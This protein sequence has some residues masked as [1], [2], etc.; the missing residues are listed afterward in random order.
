MKSKGNRETYNMR[1]SKQILILAALLFSFLCFPV[2]QVFA[3]QN[4]AEVSLKVKQKFIV[5]NPVKEMEFTGNYEFCA[6]DQEAPIPENAKDGIY[7]FSLNGEQA[8]T[9]LSLK[10]AR[11]GVYRY[12][13]KQT[14]EDKDKYQYDKSCYE[15]T[16]YVKNGE[17]GEFITQ[18]IAE[19]GDGKKSGEL[20]F[21]NSYQGNPS[22][23]SKPSDLS[24]PGTPGKPVKTGDTTPIM[25]YVFIAAG[26]LLLIGAL[27]WFRK[28]NQK[29][30]R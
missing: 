24:K 29:K 8:E 26:A 2:N 4:M 20:E 14:T 27:I 6:L 22:E 16:V 1:K 21:Q 9:K 7:S 17:N 11:A 18:V 25:L 5:K 28:H 3:S 23:P 15:I 10:Y 13:L 30:N 12:Q 19:K